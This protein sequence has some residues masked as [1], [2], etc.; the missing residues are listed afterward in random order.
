MVDELIMSAAEAA[1]VLGVSMNNLRQIQH[2]SKAQGS[3]LMWVKKSGR[4]VYYRT[5]DVLAFKE[6]RR[7]SK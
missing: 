6:T 5:A 7:G 1:E 4:N 3:G 2:R